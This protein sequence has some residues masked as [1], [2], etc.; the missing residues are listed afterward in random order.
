VALDIIDTGCGMKPISLAHLFEAFF[1]RPKRSE[2]HRAWIGDRLWNCEAELRRFSV[3]SQPGKG[4]PFRI[5][6]YPRSTCRRYRRG[7][8]PSG[9]IRIEGTGTVLVVEDEDVVR[10]VA[11]RAMEKCGYKVM[12]A[13][14][15]PS[16][17]MGKS[18]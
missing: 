1:S 11:V 15:A 2:R 5:S 14:Q 13:L 16:A 6:F 7:E 18:A 10:R 4:R 17:E 8:I 12:S 3:E 9:G